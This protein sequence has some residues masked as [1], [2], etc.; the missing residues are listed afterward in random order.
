MPEP[1]RMTIMRKE[2]DGIVRFRICRFM[3]DRYKYLDSEEHE[4]Y[5]AWYME[6][7]RREK[8]VKKTS[9]PVIVHDYQQEAIARANKTIYL[10]LFFGLRAASKFL[11]LTFADPCFD[12]ARVKADVGIMCKRFLD[13]YGKPLAYLSVL[14]LH[15]GGHG[16]HVHICVNC[17]YISQAVWQDVLWKQGIVD[18]RAIKSPDKLNRIRLFANYLAKY[19]EKDAVNAPPG[20]RRFNVS[21]AWPKLPD[22]EFVRHAGAEGVAAYLLSCQ[23]HPDQEVRDFLCTLR[24][25]EQVH[26]LEAALPATK[27]LADVV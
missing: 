5:N 11:T 17:R 7:Y 3:S 27:E 21:Q 20:S 13:R 25:G 6:K 23:D 16:Y 10:L 9:S 1:Y 26:I 19:L 8:I 22:K 18:I 14:E 15:P 12:R 2:V 4:C 24:T